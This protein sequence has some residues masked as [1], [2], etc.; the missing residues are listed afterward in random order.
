[1]SAVGSALA[2]IYLVQWTKNYSI[3][4]LSFLGLLSGIGFFQ[5]YI[6][7]ETNNSLKRD[8]IEEADNS[9]K[10]EIEERFENIDGTQQS[11]LDSQIALSPQP[12][13]QRRT[14]SR[15]NPKMLSSLIEMQNVKNQPAK[16]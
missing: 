12:V 13:F 10:E 1:M 8:N 5:T 6:L 2:P 9:H 7:E 3:S 15:M 11:L 14:S 4:P 16:Q